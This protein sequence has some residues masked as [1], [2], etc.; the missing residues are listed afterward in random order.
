MNSDQRPRSRATGWQRLAAA[1]L[2]L[3]AGPGL[4]HAEDWATFGL[5]GER[6][7]LS[8]ERS[9]SVFDGGG[10]EHRSAPGVLP[11]YRALLA[12]PAIGDGYLVYGTQ[13]NRLRALRETDWRDGRDLEAFLSVPG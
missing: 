3:A 2:A 8:P 4:A 10:W 1:L 9:G 11:A 7:R 5:V 13:R 12:S 6:T